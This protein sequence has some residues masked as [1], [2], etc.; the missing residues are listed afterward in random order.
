MS[1][2]IAVGRGS[3]LRRLTEL[4][5]RV[6]TMVDRF[7]PERFRVYGRQYFRE[8]LVPRYLHRGQT[9]Y[10]VGGGANPFLLPERKAR[11][12]A[13]VIGLDISAAELG[14][15]PNG[16]YDAVV[17]ADIAAYQGSGDADLVICQSVL[18]HVHD[19][20]GAFRSL[21]S[22][23]RP[24]WRLLLFVPNRNAFF[25]RL[26]LLLPEALKRRILFGLYPEKEETSGFPVFYDR[27]T[28]RDFRALATECGLAVEEERHF[29]MCSYFFGVLPAYI[30]WRLWI[31]IG[32]RIFGAQ[33]ASTFCMVLRK[34]LA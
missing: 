2:D 23:L 22:L 5:A 1:Q 32:A 31:L 30:F 21:A 26:N 28:P 15:A 13:R 8:T 17:S 11:L 16:S 29:F 18:E 24:G 7:L 14:G 20:D 25:A 6:S 12:A 4:Q 34:P 9:I 3:S 27:C 19:V 10:D 33:A